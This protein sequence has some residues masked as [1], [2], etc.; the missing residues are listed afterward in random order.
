MEVVEADGATDNFP[1][2]ADLGS[3]LADV[4]LRAEVVDLRVVLPATGFGAVGMVV[5]A[6]VDKGIFCTGECAGCAFAGAFFSAALTLTCVGVDCIGCLP[7]V[8]SPLAFLACK[9]L[10]FR[11]QS[12]LSFSGK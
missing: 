12:C 9:D 6:L 10:A 11:F 3:A 5:F 4:V 1:L 8:I 2:A 7:V